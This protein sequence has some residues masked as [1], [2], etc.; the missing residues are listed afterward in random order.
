VHVDQDTQAEK[1]ASRAQITRFPDTLPVFRILL[2]AEALAIIGAGLQCALRRPLR[3]DASPAV[4]RKRSDREAQRSRFSHRSAAWRGIGKRPRTTRTIR[5]P[6]ITP[7]P[8]TVADGRQ[9]GVSVDLDRLQDFGLAVLGCS[10]RCLSVEALSKQF[11]Q[12]GS[13]LVLAAQYEE[14][15]LAAEPCTQ[16]GRLTA[17]FT[18]A[19][20]GAALEPQVRLAIKLILQVMSERFRRRVVSRALERAVADTSG[21]LPLDHDCVPFASISTDFALARG[22]H[23]CTSVSCSSLQMPGCC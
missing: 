22:K 10:Q 9:G 14:L 16:C 7:E 17:D 13:R 18:V 11:L 12:A 19:R 3:Y 5:S 1:V 20:R 15:R 2:R 23:V 8:L 6:C 4:L 21:T